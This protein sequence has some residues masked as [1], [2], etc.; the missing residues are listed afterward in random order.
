MIPIK[1][2]CLIY[3][4]SGG[5]TAGTGSNSNLFCG[6]ILAPATAATTNAAVKTSEKPFQIHVKFD[7]TEV[8]TPVTE[9]GATDI[10]FQIKYAQ[11]AC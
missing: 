10:G 2:K 4:V 8:E 9:V 1:Y 6:G 3:N 7:A 5:A 11:T